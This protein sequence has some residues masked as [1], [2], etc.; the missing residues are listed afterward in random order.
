MKNYLKLLSCY[1]ARA[2]YFVLGVLTVLILLLIKGRK[3]FVAFLRGPYLE[4]ED[5]DLTIH[6]NI[7]SKM[8][9]T[10]DR[11]YNAIASEK[12][13]EMIESTIKK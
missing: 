1:L 6:N 7:Y 8:G 12:M 11:E 5:E 2:F 10:F 13:A 3:G 9:Y 4:V